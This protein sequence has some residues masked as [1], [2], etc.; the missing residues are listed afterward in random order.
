[1]A[2]AGAIAG[3]AGVV[4]KGAQVAGG[5]AQK[6]KERRAGR[7][8]LMSNILTSRENIAGKRE[9]LGLLGTQSE[10]VLAEQAR[11]TGQELGSQRA[12]FAGSGVRT[13]AGG[14]TGGLRA[15]TQ[16]IRGQERAALEKGFDVERGQLER[17]ISQLG[18]EE[19][20]QESALRQLGKGGLF[21]KGLISRQHKK[22]LKGFEFTEG[23]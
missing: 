9:Q 20:S 18:R 21:K 22:Q 15:G 3:I 8:E 5:I 19:E 14:T 1:M 17:D 16:Q 12:S 11:T 23:F 4:G 10:Q 6:S 2:A 7:E 13:G